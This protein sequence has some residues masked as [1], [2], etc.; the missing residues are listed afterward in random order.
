MRNLENKI[1]E[2][3]FEGTMVSPADPGSGAGGGKIGFK[4]NETDKKSAYRRK[5]ARRKRRERSRE[6][7]GK[8]KDQEEIYVETPEEKRARLNGQMK[9]SLKETF[10][11]DLMEYASTRRSKPMKDALSLMEEYP[12]LKRYVI[13]QSKKI[14]PTR[15]FN[16]YSVRESTMNEEVGSPGYRSGSNPHNWCLCKEQAKKNYGAANSYYVMECK[17]LPKHVMI[18]LPAFTKEIENLIYSG[19]IDEPEQNVI[20]MIKQQNEVILPGD[21]DT[22]LIVEVH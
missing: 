15:S 18:Y 22:G 12:K 7:N 10:I 11:N 21:I 16:A 9:L 8:Q 19:K 5:D 13:E 20:R 3:L 2:L 4:V 6:K 17:I 1:R 14:L